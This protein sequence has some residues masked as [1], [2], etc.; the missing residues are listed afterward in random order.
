MNILNMV[1]CICRRW[2]R[3]QKPVVEITGVIDEDVPLPA[4]V[5]VWAAAPIDRRQSFSGSGMP[6]ANP[7]MA[8]SNNSVVLENY[9]DRDF[10]V[11]LLEPNSFYDRCGSVF[12]PPTVF[13]RVESNDDSKKVATTYKVLDQ[14]NAPFRA[15]QYT[16]PDNV[17]PRDNPAFYS[18]RDKLPYRSQYEILV[19]SAYPCTD[20]MPKNFWGLKPPQ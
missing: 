5:T 20:S 2:V 19:D 18:G 7:E 6:F 9:N 4:K 13:V 10:K 14:V 8:F 1:D 11:V 17:Q 3:Q 12:V 15:L 16:M